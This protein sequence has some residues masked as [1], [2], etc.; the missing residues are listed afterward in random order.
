MNLSNK[1]GYFR[2]S[3]CPSTGGQHLDHHGARRINFVFFWFGLVS[4]GAH[5][6]AQ[7]YRL[8]M[9]P[10]LLVTNELIYGGV[11]GGRVT[12]TT[13]DATFLRSRTQVRRHHSRPG[14]NERR[15]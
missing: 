13:T 9:V 6:L 5:P 7:L 12:P 2:A 8:F 1:R 11:V 4:D 10:W 3:S 15:G 14:G